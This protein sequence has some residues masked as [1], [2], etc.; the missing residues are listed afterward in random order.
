[1][2]KCNYFLCSKNLDTRVNNGNDDIFG[3]SRHF[4]TSSPPFHEDEKNPPF[5][6]GFLPPRTGWKWWRYHE[7]SDKE[8]LDHLLNKQHYDKREKPPTAGNLSFSFF[9]P[10]GIKCNL[11]LD[12]KLLA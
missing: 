2:T 12:E 9:V 11:L 5:P 3:V 4:P 8:I 10:S 6:G 7:M 1:M